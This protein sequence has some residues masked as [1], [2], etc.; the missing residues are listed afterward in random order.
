[1]QPPAGRPE[2]L[3][4]EATL[5]NDESTAA[6]VNLAPL[7]GPSLALQLMDEQGSP[8]LLPPPPVP[9]GE[10][11]WVSLAPGES[12]RFRFS[13]FVPS[14]T[15]AGH[16]RVRLRYVYQPPSPGPEDWTGELVSD[17]ADIDVRS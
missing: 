12:R 2:D 7:A 15:A 1:M 9:G 4:A 11:S 3:V 17:W 14:W 10:P 8:V 5:T 13:G 16:Y 6:R